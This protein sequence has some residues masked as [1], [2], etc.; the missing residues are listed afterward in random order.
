MFEVWAGTDVGGP[1]RGAKSGKELCSECEPQE[2]R[3][4]G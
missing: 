4:A 2:R 3:S 1:S